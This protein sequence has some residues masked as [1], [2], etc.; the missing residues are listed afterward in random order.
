MGGI[1]CPFKTKL[2]PY[3]FT[4]LYLNRGEYLSVTPLYQNFQ[5]F[6]FFTFPDLSSLYRIF[7]ISA[8]NEIVAVVCLV[9]QL[10]SCIPLC[11]VSTDCKQREFHLNISDDFIKSVCTVCV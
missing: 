2:L 5:N 7:V 11:D 9:V 3:S 10:D 8:H 1:L 4:K 6:P